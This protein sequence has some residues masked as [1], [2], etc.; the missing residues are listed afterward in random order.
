MAANTYS[1]QFDKNKLGIL[2][3]TKVMTIRNESAFTIMMWVKI[4]SGSTSPYQRLLVERQATSGKIRLAVTPLRDL[5]R[6]EFGP[7]DGTDDINYD[8][9]PPTGVT[10]DN[11]LW[12]H[13]A[14]SASM[15]GDTSYNIIVNGAVVATGEL[16]LPADTTAV[17]DTA[18]AGSGVYLGNHLLSGSTYNRTKTGWQ[19]S[20][21]EIMLFKS[22]V[23]AS[24]P[25]STVRRFRFR[26]S[27]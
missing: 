14:F 11:D 17:S 27:S 2:D 18:M 23:S 5:I 24:R 8:Y 1:L 6:F 16:T 4:G 22:A 19:G 15:S 3:T 9:R 7:K 20:V 21:D 13:I 26:S 10:F 25:I 12:T